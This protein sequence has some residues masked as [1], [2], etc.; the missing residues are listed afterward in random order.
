MRE[1]LIS[2]MIIAALLVAGIALAAHASPSPVKAGEGGFTHKAP[3]EVLVE[4]SGA[5]EARVRR[6]VSEM[7]LV[8]AARKLGVLKDFV[9]AMVEYKG[10]EI[11]YRA[12]TGIITEEEAASR[13][14]AI[15]KRLAARIARWIAVNWL[16]LDQQPSDQGTLPPVDLDLD[17]DPSLLLDDDFHHW[18]H[19]DDGTICK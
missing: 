19:N 12:E 16:G 17:F 15:A 11:D 2:L 10:D 4:V 5:K 9:K 1:R 7:G 3:W 14:E 13:K 18:L 8:R 6:L